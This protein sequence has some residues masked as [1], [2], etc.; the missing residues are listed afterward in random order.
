MQETSRFWL[1]LWLVVGLFSI[2]AFQPASGTVSLPDTKAGTSDASTIFDAK[3][4]KCHGKDGRAHTLR[5]KLEH[6]RDLTDANWQADVSDERIFNSINNGR[7][8]MPG[9]NKKL[10]EDQINALVTYVRGLKR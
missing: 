8:K 2:F 1:A 4:A 7:N 9:F 5:G 10:T 3:C 6:A